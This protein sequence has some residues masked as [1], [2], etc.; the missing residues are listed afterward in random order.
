MVFM[1]N[2]FGTGIAVR[3]REALE[4]KTW[5]NFS[6]IIVKILREVLLKWTIYSYVFKDKFSLFLF[7][8]N[9]PYM[10]VSVRNVI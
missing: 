8:L 4:S 6:W 1:Q 9:Y 2:A 7:T 5:E 3:I 10:H